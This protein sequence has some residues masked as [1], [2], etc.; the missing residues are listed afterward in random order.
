MQLTDIGA[1]RRKSLSAPGFMHRPGHGRFALLS[2]ARF[3]GR[4]VFAC[5]CYEEPRLSRLFISPS[6]CRYSNPFLSGSRVSLLAFMLPY[7]AGD[8]HS[9]GRID[10]GRARPTVDTAPMYDAGADP[11]AL[12]VELQLAAR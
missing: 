7:S 6:L 3:L 1:R 12:F 8:R 10:G 11:T 5:A 2:C 4:Q 9:S